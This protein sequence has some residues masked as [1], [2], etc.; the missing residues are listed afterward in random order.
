MPLT[1]DH[2]QENLTENSGEIYP[3]GH[4]KVVINVGGFKMDLISHSL[5]HVVKNE[6]TA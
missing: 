2:N 6:P 4:E 5:R 3:Y 1:R